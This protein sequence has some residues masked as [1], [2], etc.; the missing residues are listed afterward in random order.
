MLV[1]FSKQSDVVEMMVGKNVQL[2]FS[3]KYFENR[4]PLVV[5]CRGGCLRAWWVAAPNS[6]PSYGTF[7]YKFLAVVATLTLCLSTTLL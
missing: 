2:P 5:L 7:I 1:P 3:V 4:L 6:S